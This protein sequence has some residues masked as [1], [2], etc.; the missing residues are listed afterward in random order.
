VAGQYA[1]PCR[2]RQLA[3]VPHRSVP[4]EEGHPD[5]RELSPLAAGRLLA[6]IDHAERSIDAQ[7]SVAAFSFAAAPVLGLATAVTI[8]SLFATAPAVQNA[9]RQ[10]GGGVVSGAQAVGAI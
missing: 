1:G 2:A 8:G 7:P 3:A 6:G 4:H 10:A 9:L 5:G